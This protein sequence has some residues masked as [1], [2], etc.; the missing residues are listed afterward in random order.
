MAEFPV[1][2]LPAL[3][4]L[5]V[6]GSIINGRNKDGYVN[7]TAMCKAAGKSFADYDRLK[8]TQAFI[9]ELSLDMGI[10]ISKLVQQFRGKPVDQQGTWVHPL[11]AINLG[12]WLSPKFAVKISKWVYGWSSAAPARQEWL[13]ERS[14]GKPVQKE[15][16]EIIAPRVKKWNPKNGVRLCNHGINLGILGCAAKAFKEKNNLPLKAL[17]RDAFSTSQ[18][19]MAKLTAQ[20]VGEIVTTKDMWD[21]AGKKGQIYRTCKETAREI[22]EAVEAIRNRQLSIQ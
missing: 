22:R 11:L 3:I 15:F 21:E 14:E 2:K 4:P 19:T 5:K 7:A 6:E 16:I 20:T 8:T 13:D 12:Q 10:H 1:A 9:K 18:L 17:T